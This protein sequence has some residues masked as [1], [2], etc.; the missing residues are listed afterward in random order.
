MAFSGFH[1]HLHAMSIN[2]DI[3]GRATNEKFAFSLLLLIPN[4]LRWF[5]TRDPQN[6][7]FVIVHR[8]TT[9]RKL[10][11]YGYDESNMILTI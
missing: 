9:E 3:Q 8:D 6:D 7:S 10:N 1:G 2:W 5:L 11:Y 4:F